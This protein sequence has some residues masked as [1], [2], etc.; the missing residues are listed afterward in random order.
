ML[1][2]A[3]IGFIKMSKNRNKRFNFTK[4]TPPVQNAD[5]GFESLNPQNFTNESTGG[6]IAESP[7]QN[8][9][10]NYSELTNIELARIIV[11]N[12][13]S[14][15]A[16]STLNRL[17]KD[18]LI[19]ICKN[20]S[21]ESLERVSK[22][23]VESA[24]DIVTAFIDLLDEVHKARDGESN[25]ESLKKFTA[26]QSTSLAPFLNSLAYSNFGLLALGA[27]LMLLAVDSFWGF[28]RVGG[29]FGFKSRIVEVSNAKN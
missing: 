23:N 21:D 16:E 26:K 10:V 24:N 25:K 12:S 1:D 2:S 20:Q 11:E 6:S 15:R 4:K 29:L 14:Q 17:S 9:K 19:F 7:A 13:W 18:E 27:G 22:A 28:K 3:D 5:S 8:D